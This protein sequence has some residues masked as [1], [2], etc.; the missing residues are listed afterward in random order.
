[1]NNALF[2]ATFGTVK[3]GDI[4]VVTGSEARHAVA[5]KRITLGE[6]VLVADGRGRAVRGAT[7]AA[8]KDRLAV[9]V[10]ELLES[11][12]RP[13][14]CVVVQALA[15]GD[16]SER[17]VE[18]MTELGVDEILAWQAARSIVRWQGER[19]AKS[20][21]KWVATAREATKQSRRYRV[22]DVGI[23]RTQ[24]V[25]DR[26]HCADRALILH[27]SAEEWIGQVKLPER[28]EVLLIVGPEGGISPEELA[29]FRDAGAV[30]VLISDAVLRTS[31]AGTVAL[32]QLSVLL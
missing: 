2:L 14:R 3:H 11:P 19:A 22:P 28:G 1:M 9:E 27:E 15:K 5:V 20:L 24:D 18:M 21:A 6:S 26:I 10:A 12:A 7:V 30:P 4:V 31:T 25:V 8:A 32:G 17:A 29:Q 16:R 13:H 23:V